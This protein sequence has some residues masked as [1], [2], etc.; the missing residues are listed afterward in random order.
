MSNLF[1]WCERCNEIANIAIRKEVHGKILAR[2]IIPWWKDE[3]YL[4]DIFQCAECRAWWERKSGPT[5]TFYKRPDGTYYLPALEW[6]KGLRAA[7]QAVSG[8]ITG[9]SRFKSW[10]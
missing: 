6:R 2:N 7:A 10:L 3:V 4:P 5:L 8:L 9:R 1:S